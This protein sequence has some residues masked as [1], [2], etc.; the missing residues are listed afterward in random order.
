M[1]MCVTHPSCLK[2]VW[3]KELKTDFHIL[4][5]TEL[6]YFYAT[7]RETGKITTDN[8]RIFRITR[9]KKNKLQN[10]CCGALFQIISFILGTKEPGSQRLIFLKPIWPQWEFNKFQ[11]KLI[12]LGKWNLQFAL[13]L[14]LMQ[15]I[16]HFAR[17]LLT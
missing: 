4:H 13:A 5:A 9:F 15:K 14:S 11:D 2:C 12:N 1:K 3:M 7:V 16:L 17:L 8:V 10:H 6:F